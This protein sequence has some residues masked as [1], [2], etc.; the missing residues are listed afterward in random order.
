MR[1]STYAERP[2]GAFGDTG[3][4]R[5]FRGNGVTYGQDSK[6]H[7]PGGAGMFWANEL[8]QL[9]RDARCGRF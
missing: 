1:S 8:E 7:D 3:S 6:R 9:F 2:T 4:W 5:I